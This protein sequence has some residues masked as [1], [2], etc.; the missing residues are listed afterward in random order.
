MGLLD[1]IE[2]DGSAGM[3]KTASERKA[4]LQEKG[5]SMYKVGSNMAW[6]HVK[7]AAEEVANGSSSEEKKD[8]KDKMSSEERVEARTKE[9]YDNM[10]KEKE[11]DKGESKSE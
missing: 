6:E 3:S 1:L 5:L 10:K 7:K 9:I 11:E 8:D 4:E 2:N